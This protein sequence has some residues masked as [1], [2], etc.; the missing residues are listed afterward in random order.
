MPVV[1]QS[2]P[3]TIALPFLPHRVNSYPRSWKGFPISRDF[4]LKPHAGWSP[5]H[6]PSL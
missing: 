3:F 4:L 2:M 5:R 6:R 1:R